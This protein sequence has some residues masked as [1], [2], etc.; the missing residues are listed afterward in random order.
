MI[1]H[2]LAIGFALSAGLTVVGGA[3][4]HSTSSPTAPNA[5]PRMV[6]ATATDYRLSMP[7]TLT[8]GATTIRLV[9]HGREMHQVFLVRLLHNKGAGDLLA[10]M[11]TPGPF[12]KWAVA[13]GG[14]NG[15]DPSATS[16]ST[17]VDL[18]PGRYAALCVIPGPDQVPHVMKG[19]IKDLFVRPSA[20][21]GTE[22]AKPDLT[23]SLT[24]Y[25]FQP[26]QPITRGHHVIVVKNVGAQLHELEL[27]EL[28][29]GK[30]PA[31]LGRWAEKMQGPPPARF[32]GGVSPLAPGHSNELAVDLAP[33]HYVMLCFVPDAKDG[34]PHVAH[35]MVR[36]FV[37]S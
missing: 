2:H 29:P 4:S 14:P 24:D 27:T 34:K 7:D 9:N 30:T 37:V 32:L 36:D 10:A 1:S 28:A 3:G 8:E 20:R 26:S 33:G 19:M 23:I 11:K 15:V 31:D 25:A 18:A 22:D 5:A 12:P 6:T 16:L 17:T 35:G 21:K 13:V